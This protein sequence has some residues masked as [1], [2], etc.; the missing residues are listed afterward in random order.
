MVRELAAKLR[1]PIAVMGTAKGVIDET[2]PAYI[3]V[4]AGA[5]SKPQVRSTIENAECLMQFA[6]RFIDSTTAA[7]SQQ[8]RPQH[9]I[10]IR[11]WGAEID[12][13]DYQGICMRDTI[14]HLLASV[15]SRSEFLTK[16]NTTP[17]A[18]PAKELTQAW[19]WKKMEQF[20]QVGDVVIAENGTSLNGTLGIRLP[21]GTDVICQALWGAIGYTLPAT[22]GSLVA[23]PERRHVLFIGDGSF[24]LTAQ[25]LSSIL[26]HKLKPIIFLINNEG[27][28]IERLIL[29]ENSSYN[30]IQPWKYAALCDVFAA[31]AAFESRTVTTVDEMEDALQSAAKGG[32]CF[33]IE[34][35]MPRMD[36]PASLKKLGPI[37]ASQ[38]YG[39]SWELENDT[40]AISQGT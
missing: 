18:A 16:D 39:K 31:G 37:Y 11:A 17:D 9:S 24:Q 34:I 40:Q 10:A 6:V 27:Y 22:F 2:D 35:M 30:D 7:F 20:L 38:D 5:L 4:Y 28:T 1:C 14:A 25:E 36:A 21:S 3:G 8:I 32:K 29:G 26:R 23:A 19:F 12:G 15:P 33:F 13:E